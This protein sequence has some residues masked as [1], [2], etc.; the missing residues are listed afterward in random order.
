MQKSL[1]YKSKKPGSRGTRIRKG[2]RAWWFLTVLGL[3]VFII[4]LVFGNI[5]L[6]RRRNELKRDLS[7]LEGRLN[8]PV[9][10]TDAFIDD[11]P[12]YLEQAAREELN[13]RKADEKVVAF[14][15]RIEEDVDE[16]EGLLQKIKDKL[17]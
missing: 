8:A 13:L 7:D 15:E 1:R 10:Q 6:A 9:S 11:S 4:G 5:E 12:A 2:R 3:A 14:P 17:K 16:T